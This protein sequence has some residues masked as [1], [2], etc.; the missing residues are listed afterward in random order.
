[1]P[2]PPNRHPVF[3]GWWIVVATSSIMLYTSGVIHFG[4][5][6]VFEP[7][8]REFG[9][10]YAQVSLAASLRGLETGLISPVLGWMV[11]RWGARKLV[12]GGSIVAALGMILLSR[13]DSLWTFYAAFILIAIG[14]STSGHGV[15]APAVV[16]WF[17]R[18]MGTAMGIMV[19]GAALGGLL[20]PL[21]ALLVDALGW[22]SAMLVMGLGTLVVCLPLSL[23]IRGKP[24]KYGC[25]P[26]GDPQAAPAA[27][28]EA[29][30]SGA[31]AGADVSARQA[32]RRRAF[33]QIAGALACQ[34]IVISAVLTHVMPFLS[35]VGVSRTTSS[36]IASGLPVVSILGRLSFG[37][38]ADRFDKK[39][40]PPPDFS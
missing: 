10:S 19:S 3:Y 26:D 9:W 5:T 31:A 16:N 12:F 2:S 7:I 34:S 14:I 32:I 18:R 38:F 8:A 22:R 25:Q 35:S 23:L 40:W 24:E 36:L 6:A 4:F 1:M 29:A 33:W 11:D 39:R 28:G 17:R 27:A 30:A 21:V 13:I 37:W 15:M 20:V